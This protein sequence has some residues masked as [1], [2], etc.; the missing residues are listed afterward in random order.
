MLS[1]LSIFDTTNNLINAEEQ[2]AVAKKE[3]LTGMSLEDAQN[4]LDDFIKDAEKGFNDVAKSFEDTMS[5]AMLNLIKKQYMNE[6]LEAW[7]DD[8]AKAM[9][10]DS[11]SDAE[12]EALRD[13]YYAIYEEG[14]KRLDSMK[15]VIGG[16]SSMNQQSSVGVTKTASQDSIDVLDGRLTHI[17]ET[18]QEISNNST[19]TLEL[20]RTNFAMLNEKMETNRGITLQSMH[21]LADISKHTHELYKTN[22]LLNRISKGTDKL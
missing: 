19:A 13:Q 4:G 3:S 7:Y 9:D 20:M 21:H 12:V 22:K 16:D 17:Q 11:L 14:K 1:K 10:D 18:N 15:E 2:L 5:N 8:F 6:A